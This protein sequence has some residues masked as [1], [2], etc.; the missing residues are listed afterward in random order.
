MNLDWKQ[1]VFTFLTVIF[2]TLSIFYGFVSYEW[3]CEYQTKVFRVR[4]CNNVPH[5]VYF[6]IAIVFFVL[7]LLA[8]RHFNWQSIFVQRGVVE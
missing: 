3:I 2:G 6:F 5:G 4:H 1:I 7:T 8:Y